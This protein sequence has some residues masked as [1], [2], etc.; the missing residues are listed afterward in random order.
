[1]VNM[2]SEHVDSYGTPI[3]SGDWVEVTY[4]EFCSM[5]AR[6]KIHQVFRICTKSQLFGGN[7]TFVSRLCIQY[8]DKFTLPLNFDYLNCSDISDVLHRKMGED[9]LIEYFL[10]N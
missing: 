5:S 1:M 4:P 10:K 7:A 6:S 9:E 8:G 3:A 2:N